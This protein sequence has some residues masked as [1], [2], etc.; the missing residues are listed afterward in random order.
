M[1][2]TGTNGSNAKVKSKHSAN[3]LE[4]NQNRKKFPQEEFVSDFDF[5]FNGAS[6][7]ENNFV[8]TPGKTGIKQPV[9]ERTSWN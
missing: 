4:V 7:K 2:N 3:K 6:A 8:E 1:S 9:S 5:N